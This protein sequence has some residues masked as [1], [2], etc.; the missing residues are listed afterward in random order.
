VLAALSTGGVSLAIIQACLPGIDVGKLARLARR[1]STKAQ[2]VFVGGCPLAKGEQ[3]PP[4][5]PF[6]TMTREGLLDSLAVMLLGAESEPLPPAAEF[7]VG[8][9]VSLCVLSGPLAGTYDGSVVDSGPQRVC[10]SAW[11]PDGTPVDLSLGTPVT[12][13]F[14]GPRG[15][16][17]LR[18]TVT[19]S[20]VRGSVIE[21]TLPRS[22]EVSYRQRRKAERYV[23][24]YPMWAWPAEGANVSN[25]M[26]SGR[27]ED[28]SRIGVRACFSAALAFSG[29]AVLS[30]APG[31]SRRASRLIAESVWHEDV[32]AS[33]EHR[34]GFRFVNLSGAAAESLDGLL[35]SSRS[36]GSG[37]ITRSSSADDQ[38]PSPPDS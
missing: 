27:T 6:R 20:Y 25:R 37:R 5:D 36:W 35:A 2:L 1:G 32:P 10:I 18:S 3:P 28:I 8:S 17:E 15:W 7:E 16:G 23:A 4:V 38:G 21:L 22:S 12:A 14:A 13:G 19:G 9:A 30:I 34:Y 24:T 33:G 26:A 29:R 31:R 11:D